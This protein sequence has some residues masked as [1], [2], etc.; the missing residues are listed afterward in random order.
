[1]S[2]HPW[3]YL[4]VW[5]K[6]RALQLAE[7]PFCCICEMVDKLTVADTVDHKIPFRND[8]NL[9]IDR[10][11]HQSVCRSCH[12][13]HKQIQE[14]SGAL[15]GCDVNGMPIDPNHPWTKGGAS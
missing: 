13:R 9:F 7:F 5:K 14:K 10:N 11:N 3:Y 2:N 6:L 1:V 12:S 8:W 15:P 4:P